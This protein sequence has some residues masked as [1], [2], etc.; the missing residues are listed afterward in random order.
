MRYA[1]PLSAV[2][3]IESEEDGSV[4][5]VKDIVAT[6]PYLVG[7][8]P[9]FTIYPGVF[10]I[11]TV[12]QT[13]REVLERSGGRAELVGITSVRFSAPLLPGD[14]LRAHCEFTPDPA[15]PALVRVKARCRRADDAVSAQMTLV[16]RV[17]PTTEETGS[18]GAR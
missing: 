8:Y 14:R 10:S 15:D 16:L 9:D 11:E 1:A 5:G 17:H 7:H 2:D 13:A 3:R 6:D 12:H 4:V 18:V